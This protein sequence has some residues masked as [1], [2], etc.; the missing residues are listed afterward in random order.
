MNKRAEFLENEIKRIVMEIIQ[1]QGLS[2]GNVVAG[3]RNQPSDDDIDIIMNL[4]YK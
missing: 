2:H 3:K 4:F 1:K